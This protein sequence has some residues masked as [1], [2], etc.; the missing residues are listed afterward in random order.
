MKVY[1]GSYMYI[2]KIDLQKSKVNKDFG[3]GFYK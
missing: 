3:R 2:D 1:H